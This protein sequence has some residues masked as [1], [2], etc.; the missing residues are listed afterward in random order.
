MS[1]HVPTVRQPPGRIRKI[2][3]NFRPEEFEGLIEQMGTDLLW[4]KA[5]ICA[6]RNNNQTGQPKANCPVCL[7]DGWE[8][9]DPQMIRGVLAVMDLESD[10]QTA[11]G[12]WAMGTAVITVYAQHKPGLR[13]RYTNTKVSI[14]HSEFRRRSGVR[15]HLRYPIVEDTQDYRVKQPG[16]DHL[17]ETRTLSVLRVRRMDPVT[18]APGAVVRIGDDFDVVFEPDPRDPDGELGLPKIGKLDWTRGDLRGTAPAEGED[19]AITYMRAPR[20]RV[21]A[22][23]HA[24]RNQ[25]IKSKAPVAKLTQLPLETLCKLDSELDH[26]ADT[27]EGFGV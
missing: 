23:N 1:D 17:V 13:H 20:Y 8:Y 16:G 3:V 26:R 7:G 22:F 10:T 24:A 4:E 18:R 9:Y 21:I 15:E 27:A 5:A 19:Y 11:F 25:D 12:L 14:E 6:C 2:V